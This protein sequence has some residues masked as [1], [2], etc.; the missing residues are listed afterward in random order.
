LYWYDP[1]RPEVH[2]EQPGK[3]PFMDMDLVPKYADAGDTSTEVA[4]SAAV[5]Q[6]LG[7]RT[8]TPVLRDVRPRVRVPA[9]VV[10]D[11]RGQ[12]RLQA[13]VDGWIERLLV[14][15]VGQPVAAGSVVAEIYAPELVQAQEELLLGPDTAGPAR[16]RL[17]RLG[18]ADA[19]IERVRRSGSSMRRLPLRA[20]VA[21]VVTELGVREGSRVTP[22]TLVVDIAGRNAV[23]IEA[24][25]FPAQRRLLGRTFAARF[26]LPG[27]PGEAW[28]S[29]SGSLVPVADAITQTLAV[30]FAVGDAADLPLGT[31]LDA[32][33]DGDTRTGVLLVPASAVIR[34]SLGDRVLVERAPRRFVP[35]EVTLGQ[36]Y[37]EE[38]EIRD[39][40]AATDRIVVSGQFLL[41]AEASLQEGLAQMQDAAAGASP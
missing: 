2:F 30:R 17:R 39:G 35:T 15:A 41:D 12:A 18:I 5:I 6:S 11:A 36:R 3:S 14:R 24:Q 37:G 33:I 38:V 4:V 20:P 16:E 25:L 13:R 26:T 27:S 21:G 29:A 1:M 19:D 34:T 8:A 31:V 9:R 23:W 7:I 10:A 32:E 22:E 40:L 28:S